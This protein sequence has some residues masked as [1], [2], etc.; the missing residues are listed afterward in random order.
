MFFFKYFCIYS[1]VLHCSMFFFHSSNAMLSATS[2]KQSHP[3]FLICAPYSSFYIACFVY[4]RSAST[5]LR[6][7]EVHTS[8][9]YV[10]VVGV[11]PSCCICLCV[12]K[13]QTVHIFAFTYRCCV[14]HFHRFIAH[15]LHRLSFLSRPLWHLL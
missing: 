12:L 5:L 15:R 8:N 6:L 11:M 14:C 4:M 7:G 2:I 9:V 10:V 1:I 13:Y 3:L